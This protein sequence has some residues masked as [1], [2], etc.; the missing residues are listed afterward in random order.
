MRVHLSSNPGSQDTTNPNTLPDKHMKNQA[1]KLTTVLTLIVSLFLSSCAATQDGRLT[2]AQGTAAG[3]GLGAIGG[4]LIAAATGDPSA[5]ATAVITGATVGAIGGF[6]YGTDVA[7]KKA[8]YA[9]QEDFLD[10]A[11]VQAEKDHQLAVKNN[12]KLA[13][14]VQA[15]EQKYGRLPKGDTRGK[16]QLDKQ[17]QQQMQALEKNTLALDKRIKDYQ[18]CLS[19]DGYGSKTQSASLRQK[20]KSLEAEKAKSIQYQKRL[21]SAQSRV[22]M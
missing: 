11:I 10:M 14:Q 13:E 9:R 16:S 5:I 7:K 20:M 8:N 1:F 21:A 17:N 15:L 18:E 2:Q 3:A 12:N 19:G 22:A 6:A 4:L